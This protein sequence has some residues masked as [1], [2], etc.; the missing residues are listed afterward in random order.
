MKNGNL[1]YPDNLGSLQL[2]INQSSVSLDKVD[3]VHASCIS[4]DSFQITNGVGQSGA[5]GLDSLVLFIYLAIAVF[6]PRKLQEVPLIVIISR[7]RII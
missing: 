1:E 4:H 5:C 2:S 7:V 3:K 6:F